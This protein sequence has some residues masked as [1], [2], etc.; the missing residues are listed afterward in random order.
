[1][2]C[3]AY[4]TRVLRSQTICFLYFYLKIVMSWRSLSCFFPILLWYQRLFCEDLFNLFSSTGSCILAIWCMS[5]RYVECGGILFLCGISIWILYACITEVFIC[6]TYALTT[7]GH[8]CITLK[9]ALWCAWYFY[10]QTKHWFANTYNSCHI[11]ETS[12]L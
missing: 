5:N 10:P 6:Y 3:F 2:I 12:L 7:N 1:M 9:S 11:P 8:Q 4:Y